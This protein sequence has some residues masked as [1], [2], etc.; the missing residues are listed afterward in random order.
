[1]IPRAMNP[2]NAIITIILNATNVRWY[3]VLR[4]VRVI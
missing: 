4:A 1:V 2:L 3:F